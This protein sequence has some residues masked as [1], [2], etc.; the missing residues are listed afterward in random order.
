MKDLNIPDIGE[1]LFS[2][3]LQEKFGGNQSIRQIFTSLLRF[4]LPR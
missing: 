1:D 4:A 2:I 3:V